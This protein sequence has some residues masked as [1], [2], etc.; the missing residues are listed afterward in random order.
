MCIN[1]TSQKK[2]RLKNGQLICI[3]WDLVVWEHENKVWCIYILKICM[4]LINP[5]ICLVYLWRG[6]RKMDWVSVTCY[7]I[8]KHQTWE[9]FGYIRLSDGQYPHIF[10]MLNNE[11]LFFSIFKIH[12]FNIKNILYWGIADEQCCGSFRWTA[13]GLSHTYTCIH[14]PPNSLPYRLAYNIEQSSMCYTIGLCW[15][16]I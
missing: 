2:K 15:L 11:N 7:L 16:S 6:K 5:Q 9:K 14:S 3:A 13:E 4:R 10:Y 8:K 12:S 1:F